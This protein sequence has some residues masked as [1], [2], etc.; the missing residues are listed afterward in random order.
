[1]SDII[2]TK[3]DSFFVTIQGEGKY[4]GYPSIFIRSSYCNLRCSWFYKN[5]I[6]KCDTAHSSFNPEN[7]KTSID[8]L[9]NE[10]K[11]YPNIDHV[12]ITGG[13]PTLQDSLV[14]LVSKL[15]DSGKYI[16]IETNGTVYK[17]TR[18]QFLSLSPKL[19][20][21]NALNIE[22]HDKIRINHKVLKRYMED[23]EYQFKF[24]YSDD[25]DIEEILEIQKILQIPNNKIY[26]MPQ[27][28]NPTQVKENAKKAIEFCKKYN[29][30][31]CHRVHVCIWGKKKGV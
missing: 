23:H 27:G 9:I 29:W 12:V 31:Y 4:T 1:M 28:T 19:S 18:A 15:V 24:V 30:I 16:T 5:K 22:S 11:K 7:I 6:V 13:E 25:K 14:E 20:S 17:Q 3:S 10:V 2:L 26:I 21:S 8:D